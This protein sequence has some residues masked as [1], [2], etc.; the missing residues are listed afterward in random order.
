MAC[1]C[2]PVCLDLRNEANW[3]F[4]NRDRASD[5]CCSSRTHQQQNPTSD[6]DVGNAWDLDADLKPGHSAHQWADQ[7]AER[8]KAGE[9]PWVS[10][11]ISN[12][13]IFNM[14][15]APYWRPYRGS[16]PHTQHV[17]VSIKAAWRWSDVTWFE[18]WHTDKE[19]DEMATKA[20]I[21]DAVREVL[22]EGKPK[23]STSWAAG[24]KA[25][26]GLVQHQENMLVRLIKHFDL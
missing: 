1:T 14:A 15:V 10:Y 6:H 5:G 17:H 11:I 21:K 9:A 23:G 2:A 4:P 22:D 25:T 18:L 7:L 13:R 8:A 19:W 12:G 16:N 3:W 26:V 24:N 20:E